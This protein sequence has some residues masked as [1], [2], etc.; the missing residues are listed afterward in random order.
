[1]AIVHM[2]RNSWG[3][4]WKKREYAVGR[5]GNYI[6]QGGHTTA[7]QL[8]PFSGAVDIIVV[9]QEDGSLKSSPW[10]VKFGK[11]QGVLK[12]QE[13]LVALAINDVPLKFHMY[14]DPIGEAYFLM[15]DAKGISPK[16]GIGE[17]NMGLL[18]EEA[19]ARGRKSPD[20]VVMLGNKSVGKQRNSWD[21]KKLREDDED[22]EEDYSSD[23]Q[24][25][26]LESRF[27]GKK[28]SYLVQQAQ[29]SG[30]NSICNA[31]FTSMKENETLFGVKNA[32]NMTKIHAFLN[33]VLGK[34]TQN[35][36]GVTNTLIAPATSGT[37]AKVF[38]KDSSSSDGF[39]RSLS[40]VLQS[41]YYK[42]P[43]KDQVHTFI[44][45]SEMLSLMNLKEGRNRITFT[46]FTRVLGR[47]QVDAQIYLWKWN[48][49]IVITDVDGT[50]TK[51]DVLGQMMPLV[52]KDWTQLGVTRLFSAIKENGYELLFLSARAI[53]QAYVTRQFLINVKQDGEAL[54]DGPLVISP[55]GLFPSFYRAVIRKAPHEFK[56]ACLQDIRSLFPKHYNPFYAGFGNRATDEI[57]YLKVGIPKRKIFMINPKG[58]V[59]V[60]NPIDVESY[61]SLHKLV[62][63]IFPP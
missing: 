4:L 50:I 41:K 9:Q 30:R 34:D 57:S 39:P 3:A 55:V 2:F 14:L 36:S 43:P 7:V 28:T 31:T 61:T 5:L 51:S 63:E 24:E 19:L 44:P 20:L 62:D 33:E 53:S 6:S 32:S 1:M 16:T 58:E 40:K 21:H 45:S 11:F 47:Q 60:N 27:E 52:G 17:S 23:K 54:P 26:D 48:T 10:Y 42:H 35:I 18:Q 46:F 49:R 13:K 15:D 56:I 59:A 12:R 22:G 38:S 29:D 37:I 25:G 8:R